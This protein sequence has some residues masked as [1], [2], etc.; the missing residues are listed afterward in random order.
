MKIGKPF[1]LLSL[2]E[3]IF[4]IDN[5]KKY[6]DFNTL[7]L[8]RSII[9]NKK[10][11]LEEKLTLREHAHKSFKKSFDFLQLKDPFT[12]INVAYLGE[13]LTRGD[14]INIWDNVKRYQQ[15]VLADK[16]IKHR[17]FGEYSKHSCGYDN[18]HLNGIMIKKGSLFTE[19]EMYFDS[20]KSKYSGVEKS[21]RRKKERKNK[22]NIINKELDN[23]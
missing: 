19:C 8:Y 6:T 4:Y 7:G 11:T 10:L 1:Y 17:N 14:E 21:E 16:K 9:E 18:C 15:K 20:D 23:L 5:Y 12:Y 3:Y 22:K 13:E 2:K